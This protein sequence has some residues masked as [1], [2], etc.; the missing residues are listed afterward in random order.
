MELVGRTGM[1]P[2]V[3]APAIVAVVGKRTVVVAAARPM[4]SVGVARSVGPVGPVEPAG[5]EP[6]SPSD[7]AARRPGHVAVERKPVGLPT[8]GAVA[9]PPRSEHAR[10]TVDGRLLP[11]VVVAV[12]GNEGTIRLEVG[13]IQA[14]FKP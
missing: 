3:A 13:P 8:D 2:A 12:A 5:P 11:G 6:A 10:P 9:G 14:D 7:A 1:A 4:V